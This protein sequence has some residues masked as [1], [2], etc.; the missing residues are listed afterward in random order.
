MI[1]KNSEELIDLS[2]EEQARHVGNFFERAGRG[3][4]T[5]KPIEKTQEEID[6]YISELNKTKEN[7]TVKESKTNSDGTQSILYDTG[8]GLWQET[9]TEDGKRLS[10]IPVEEDIIPFWKEE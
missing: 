1:E 10:F 7:W 2:P 3:I 4:K 6:A 5:I 9:L 8:V